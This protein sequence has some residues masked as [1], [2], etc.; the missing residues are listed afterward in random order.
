MG[1]DVNHN[2]ISMHL[3][4]ESYM[5][6]A[7]PLLELKHGCKPFSGEEIKKQIN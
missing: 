5:H 3:F 1:N 7:L 6:R 2:S 4:E